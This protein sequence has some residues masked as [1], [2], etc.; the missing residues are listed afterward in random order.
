[1][2]APLIVM[3]G[4][5]FDPAIKRIGNDF[6]CLLDGRPVLGLDPGIKPGHDSGAKNSP[7]FS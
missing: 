7:M 2:A 3:A 5:G 1:M 6:N 4:M